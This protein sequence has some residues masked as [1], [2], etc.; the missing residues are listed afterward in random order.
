MAKPNPYEVILTAPGSVQLP[1][2]GL[3]WDNFVNI[4]A[5]QLYLHVEQIYFGES[6][7]REA[8]D[9]ASK[10]LVE[11]TS[12]F[13]LE[14]TKERAKA[15]VRKK[16]APKIISNITGF[17]P[18]K[19][20]SLLNVAMKEAFFV[21]P[22][23]EWMAFAMGKSPKG[24]AFYLTVKA[25][26]V[27]RVYAYRHA[28]RQYEL[29]GQQ[30]AIPF[31]IF[32]EGASASEVRNFMGKAVWKQVLKN[33]RSRNVLLAEA[34][35]RSSNVYDSDIDAVL[36]KRELQ[37]LFKIPSS[38]LK[39]G[40][41]RDR[42]PGLGLLYHVRNARPFKDLNIFDL[43]DLH[44]MTDGPLKDSYSL[45]ELRRAH[46]VAGGRTRNQLKPKEPH[47]PFTQPDARLEHAGVT[48]TRICNQ[49]QANEESRAMHH[50]LGPAYG[51]RIERGEY[52]AYR[53]D[54]PNGLR[55]TLGM[56]R[57]TTINLRNTTSRNSSMFRGLNYEKEWVLDQLEGPGRIAVVIPDLNSAI[58]KLSKMNENIIDEKGQGPVARL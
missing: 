56:R 47:N 43:L 4:T 36:R 51:R 10:W 11:G 20:V 50:C 26:I 24:G 14:D 48:Y 15:Y 13:G 8:R 45:E 12:S 44:Y 2:L 22:Y 42:F 5:E 58:D 32:Y 16:Y 29:D 21:R 25:P 41:E 33:S 23:T 49:E 9:L 28:Y 27:N 3:V 17:G 53:V 40:L 6:H 37:R 1:A 55:A 46:D 52:A 54:G 35:E 19:L 31:C 34:M 39:K 7:Q 38:L 18:N 57:S 30:V